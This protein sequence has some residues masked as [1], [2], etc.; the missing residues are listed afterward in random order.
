MRAAAL[1]AAL[2]T[3]LAA[4][5]G[6][7]PVADAVVGPPAVLA[8]V[9]VAGRALDARAFA[10]DAALLYPDET[11]SLVQSRLRT[12]FA[13][14]EAE[15]LGLD[16]DPE[17][18]D[19]A[20]DD[21]LAALAAEHEPGEDDEAFARRR[22]GRS[23]DELVAAVRRRLADNQRYQV[24]VRARAAVEGRVRVLWL[25]VE[26]EAEAASLA[27]RLR[28]GMDPR[29]LLSA[30]L[31]VG[32]E[33]DGSFPPMHPRL[34]APH[35]DALVGVEPGDVVGP[36]RFTGDRAWWVGSVREV[37][38]PLAAPPPTAR[39]LDELETRPIGPLEA[40]AW[41]E[42]MAEGYTATLGAPSVLAPEPAFVPLR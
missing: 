24:A 19:A 27:R 21:F 2:L 31:L 12:E 26:D 35:R 29:A 10:A 5:A 14:R 25:V 4:C 9:R 38:P 6:P 3:A 33:P 7:Q 23:H 40:R 34:P 30:S 8:E 41:F 16:V 37:L 17:R 36:L 18:L 20:L 15:R 32:T 11:R 39:L 42:A 13:R 22:Y 28:S 1:G